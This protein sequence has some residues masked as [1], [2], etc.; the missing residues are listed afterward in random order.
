M[1]RKMG[2]STSLSGRMAFVLYIRLALASSI[3]TFFLIIKSV[4]LKVI[5]IYIPIDDISLE[6]IIV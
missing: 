1:Q 2:R 3:S 6:Y 5:A 4:L